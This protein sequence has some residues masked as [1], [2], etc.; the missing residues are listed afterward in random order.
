MMEC[1]FVTI[2]LFAV[3]GAALAACVVALVLGLLPQL[4]ARRRADERAAFLRAQ[5]LHHISILP[6]FL[7]ERDRPLPVEHRDVLDDGCCLAQH[8][9]LLEMEEWASVLRMQA[10]LM[11]ARNRP[12]FT[13]R[14]A[15]LAQQAI[16]HTAEV[17]R[18]FAAADLHR[19]A[20]WKSILSSRRGRPSAIG[21]AMDRSLMFRDTPG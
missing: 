15:R 21:P 13:K 2:G 9:S 11:T 3:A 5:L 7:Q 1:T 10:L 4:F 14:E 18:T 19:S 6:Q 20:W 17:L 8:A 12:S 16:D